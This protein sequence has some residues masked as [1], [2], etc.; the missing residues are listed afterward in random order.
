MGF[1]WSLIRKLQVL[2]FIVGF[3]FQQGTGRKESGDKPTLHVKALQ[4]GF[5]FFV[6]FHTAL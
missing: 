2:E 1:C 3:P 5:Y 6:M 4:R